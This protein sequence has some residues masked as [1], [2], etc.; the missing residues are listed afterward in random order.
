ME[1]EN[2]LPD[3]LDLLDSKSLA[4][5]L[6]DPN[7]QTH[8]VNKIPALNFLILQKLNLSNFW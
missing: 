2:G 6:H 7:S 4:W 5:R 8:D 1:E 3:S